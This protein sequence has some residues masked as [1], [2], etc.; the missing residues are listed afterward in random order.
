MKTKAQIVQKLLEEKK[1]DADEAVI[2]L[3]SSVE[4]IPYAARPYVTYCADSN[5]PTAQPSFTFK[6]EH[7]GILN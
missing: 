6:V 7:N 3:Q 2:L 5:A 4:Y 1:I